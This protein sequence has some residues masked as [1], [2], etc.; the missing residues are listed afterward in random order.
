MQLLNKIKQ[1]NTP[2]RSGALL[3]HFLC[4]VEWCRE[5]GYL[6]LQKLIM[7]TELV[8]VNGEMLVVRHERLNAKLEMFIV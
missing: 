1:K 2:E 6:P 3:K 4:R 5:C 7:K 8:N